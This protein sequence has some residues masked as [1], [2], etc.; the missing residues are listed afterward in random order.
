MPIALDA[1]TI[2]LPSAGEILS[3]VGTGLKT[4]GEAALDFAGEAAT[5]ALGVVAVVFTPTQTAGAQDNVGAP[6]IAHFAMCGLSSQ[7]NCVE[8]TVPLLPLGLF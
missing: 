1:P 7:S 6:H 2:T 3:A 5:G 8:I 4:A